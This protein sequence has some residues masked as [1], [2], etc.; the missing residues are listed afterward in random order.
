MR[1]KHSDVLNDWANYVEM[2]S[3]KVPGNWRL[4]CAHCGVGLGGLLGKPG[5]LTIIEW[6]RWPGTWFGAFTVLE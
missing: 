4:V 2:V 6:R 1:E 5:P 3:A